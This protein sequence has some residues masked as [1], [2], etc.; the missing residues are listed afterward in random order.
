MGISLRAYARHRGVTLAAVQKARRTG[1][2]R[3]LADGSI[4]PSAA[5]AA[6]SAADAARRAAKKTPADQTRVVLSAGSLATA[7]ATV[8]AV[9]VEHGAPADKALTISDVRLVNEILK[10][11]ERADAI[12]AKKVMFRL[13]QRAVAMEAIDRRLVDSFIANAVQTIC[14]YVNPRD[15]PE[16]L[17]RLRDLQARWVPGT[18]AEAR[19]PPEDMLGTIEDPLPTAKSCS[20]PGNHAPDE[21]P[22]DRLTVEN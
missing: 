15:V 9:L 12:A 17:D 6:W 8:R 19:H 22:I 16:A 3:V 2:I 4:D 14:E 21:G 1:R 20:S 5:D 13:R 11:K 10:A 7:E 18:L